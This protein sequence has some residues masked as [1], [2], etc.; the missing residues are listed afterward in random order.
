[1]LYHI[2]NASNTLTCIGYDKRNVNYNSN[3][4]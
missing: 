4:P 1:M 2:N 3:V